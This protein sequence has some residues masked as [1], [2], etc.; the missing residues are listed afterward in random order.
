MLVGNKSDANTQRVVSKEE[1]QKLAH[2][3][4]CKFIE[5]SAR[6]NENVDKAFEDMIIQIEGWDKK[7]AAGAA[8]DGDGEP[9]GKPCTVM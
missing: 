6:Y 7:D 8:G 9:V 5:T 2:E 3:M 1:G 4:G